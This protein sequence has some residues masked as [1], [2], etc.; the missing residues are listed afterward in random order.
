MVRSSSNVCWCVDALLMIFLSRAWM[1][2]SPILPRHQQ[3]P[4][5]A[6]YQRQRTSPLRPCPSSLD[7]A[8]RMHHPP[9]R[10]ALNACVQ[11]DA[12]SSWLNSALSPH[13]G[14]LTE[15]VSRLGQQVARM[16]L[17]PQLHQQDRTHGPLVDSATRTVRSPLARPPLLPQAM[18]RPWC[19]AAFARLQSAQQHARDWGTANGQ[20]MLLWNVS[21]GSMSAVK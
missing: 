3:L 10:T 21:K 14:L 7:G 17:L 18:L 19:S 2:H 8:G 5:L 12:R 11:Q 16:H 20:S 4:A 6:L 15:L 9:G 13:S 1:F